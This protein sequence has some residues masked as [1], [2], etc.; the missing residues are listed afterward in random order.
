MFGQRSLQLFQFQNDWFTSQY[1]YPSVYTVLLTSILCLWCCSYSPALVPTFIPA[2]ESWERAWNTED[3]QFKRIA[4]FF[5]SGHYCASFHA[6]RFKILSFDST[7]S[8]VVN[9]EGDRQRQSAHHRRNP[10][11]TRVKVFDYV[12]SAMCRHTT[13]E[14]PLTIS[15]FLF[16]L[17]HSCK[18]AF[19]LPL[20]PHKL[21]WSVIKAIFCKRISNIRA[22]ALEQHW[23]L[24]QTRTESQCKFQVNSPC[25]VSV[26]W[27]IED[28]AQFLKSHSFPICS[29]ILF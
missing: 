3:D 14:P 19:D 12:N 1:P 5:C 17:Q 29:L 21:S 4:F 11:R 20:W 9:E 26:S 7:V 8:V 10:S 16:L 27:N 18:A 23:E 15:L 13:L 24:L 2:L 28:S 22:V 25:A 6:L